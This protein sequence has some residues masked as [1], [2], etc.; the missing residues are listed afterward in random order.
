MISNKKAAIK[1]S[2]TCEIKKGSDEIIF[3]GNG[4]SIKL[5]TDL[6]YEIEN[7]IRSG[8]VQIEDKKIL[9]ILMKMLSINILEVKDA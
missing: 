9:Y 5:G 6:G 2:N 8:R 4:G 7:F 3:L 1:F